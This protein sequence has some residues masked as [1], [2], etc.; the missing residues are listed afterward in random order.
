VAETFDSTLSAGEIVQ[1]LAMRKAR[2]IAESHRDA[3]I[4]GADTVVVFN[5]QILEK[6]ETSTEAKQ[7]LQSLS[8]QTHQVLTGVALCKVDGSNNITDSS[9]FVEKTDVIFGNLNPDDIAAYVTGGSPMD[10]AGGYG[11]QDDFG[12]IFVQRI[13]GDYYN[14]VGFPLH[15]FYNVMQSF[16]PEFLPKMLN[17]QIDEK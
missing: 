10:K 17:N 12:A 3:L 1:Q 9:T 4:I 14:V 5:D 6:P 13:K 16:A 7:M 2:D 8:G 15:R 11:I